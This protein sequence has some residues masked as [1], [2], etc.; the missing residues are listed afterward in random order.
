M[1]LNSKIISSGNLNTNSLQKYLS[2]GLSCVLAKRLELN[3]EDQSS[4]VNLIIEND[5]WK[6][7]LNMVNN[8]SNVDNI[9]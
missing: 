4:I 1:D 2:E 7:L 5:Y 9:F 6:N 3:I 8:S